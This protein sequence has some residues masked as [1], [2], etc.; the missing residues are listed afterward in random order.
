[1]SIGPKRSFN[2]RTAIIVV[3]GAFIVLFVVMKIINS[4]TYPVLPATVLIPKESEVIL[5][6]T[7]HA[8]DQGLVAL[9][10]DV[11]QAQGGGGGGFLGRLSGQ[12]NLEEAFPMG[13]VFTAWRNPKKEG[14]MTFFQAQSYSHYVTR[15]R[16]EMGCRPAPHGG[17][18]I[19]Y[20]GEK[21]F[22]V[23]SDGSSVAA[24]MA[25]NNLLISSD[26]GVVK[27]F[28][29]KIHGGKTEF[30]VSG[31]LGSLYKQYHDEY[32]FAVAALNDRDQIRAFLNERRVAGGPDYVKQAEEHLGLNADVIR[33]LAAGAKITSAD[34]IEAAGIALCKDDEAA[35]QLADAINA[36][37]QVPAAEGKWSVATRAEVAGNRVTVKMELA[38]LKELV[39][40]L[41]AKAEAEA[42]AA[43]TAAA[44]ATASPAPSPSA[45]APL[46]TPR[47]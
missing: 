29:D 12:V 11:R 7:L 25:Q 44:E 42:K 10:R 16:W 22:T 13:I 47:K 26:V 31:E 36:K 2:W 8:T 46:E 32:P 41:L 14:E 20:G 38:G 4:I 34:R 3:L 40:D 9:V 21:L 27:Q 18:K 37:L 28:I 19:E 39:L 33:M 1:M 15:Q 5:T 23:K 17:E 43:A 35:K 24:A 30:D 45:A 6:A